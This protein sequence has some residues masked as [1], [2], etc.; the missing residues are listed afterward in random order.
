MSNKRSLLIILVIILTMLAGTA[1]AQWFQYD[2]GDGWNIYSFGD[3]GFYVRA[4]FLPAGEEYYAVD[5]NMFGVNFEF[6]ALGGTFFGMYPTISFAASD[7]VEA[8]G[9]IKF[10]LE[11]DDT[12]SVYNYGAEASWMFAEDIYL[13]IGFNR[14]YNYNFIEVQMS[15]MDM[16][17]VYIGIMEPYGEANASGLGLSFDFI[18]GTGWNLGGDGNYEFYADFRDIALDP[19]TLRFRLK[20]GFVNTLDWDSAAE[21]GAG[22]TFVGELR[23]KG[24]YIY[25]YLDVNINMENL[26]DVTV[27]LYFWYGLST[28]DMWFEADLLVELLAVENLFCYFETWFYM[29]SA[30]EATIDGFTLAEIDAYYQWPVLLTVGYTIVGDGMDIKVYARGGA[31]IA[32]AIFSEEITRSWLAQAGAEIY[33]GG[34]YVMIPIYVAVSNA[35]AYWFLGDYYYGEMLT[36]DGSYGGIL[37]VLYP[38]MDPLHAKVYVTLGFRFL[39]Y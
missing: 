5:A 28:N 8:F 25:P 20:Y 22:R 32:G 7:T 1:S 35:D 3:I 2:P 15:N 26:V 19:I 37:A 31:D 13:R 10:V 36:G 27:A 29:E 38:S 30:A 6:G 39:L 11:P 34:G 16:M 24:G 17:A 9:R 23:N 14:S 12:V 4:N 18:T 21:Y 33:L